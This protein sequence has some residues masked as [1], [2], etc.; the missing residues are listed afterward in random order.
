MIDVAIG[1]RARRKP[2]VACAALARGSAV[3]AL[4][5][6]LLT[7]EDARLAELRGC[8]AADALVV[9][10]DEARLPWVDTVQYFGRDPAAPRL[11]LPTHSEPGVPLDLLS[12]ALGAR[13][14]AGP[15]AV[16]PRSGGGHVA[17]SLGAAAPIAR[18][19]LAAWLGSC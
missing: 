18:A 7:W 5:R 8:A 10:G 13:L 2:L 16:G 14:P 6:H 4:A 15:W 9:L 12:E 3:R 11:L 17:V 1:W 19:R